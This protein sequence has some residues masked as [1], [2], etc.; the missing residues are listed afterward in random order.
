MILDKDGRNWSVQKYEREKEEKRMQE[1]VNHGD[2]IQDGLIVY[3]V[4]AHLADMLFWHPDLMG[5]ISRIFDKD[6]TKQGK[7]AP[8]TDILVEGLDELK[9]LPAGTKIAVSAIRYYQEIAVELSALNPGLICQD[10]DDVY[11]KLVAFSLAIPE[12]EVS[13]EQRIR[14]YE[15]VENVYDISILHQKKYVGILTTQQ[16]LYVAEL[17]KDNLHMEDFGCEI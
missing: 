5:R 6:E 1:V 8:G 14:D 12:K 11:R 2:S 9:H 16:C 3:G 7:K 4:G 10:I 17:L 15:Y 13:N